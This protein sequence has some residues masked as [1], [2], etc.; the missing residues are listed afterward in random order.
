[1]VAL[2]L[3]R[4]VGILLIS[5][6][7]L[8]SLCWFKA[9]LAVSSHAA[10]SIFPPGDCRER[11]L[12]RLQAATVVPACLPA[13]LLSGGGLKGPWLPKGSLAGCYLKRSLPRSRLHPNLSAGYRGAIGDGESLRGCTR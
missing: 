1:M 13:W 12:R 3:I 8:P 2:W 4:R 11:L 5:Q 9:Y 10:F 6:I 7:T